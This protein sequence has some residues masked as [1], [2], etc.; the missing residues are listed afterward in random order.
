MNTNAYAGPDP[1]TPVTASSKPSSA[2]RTQT[3]TLRIKSRTRATSASVAREPAHA[4]DAASPTAHGVLGITR[5]T[6][7]TSV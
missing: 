1:L 6:R 2:T 7:G 5:T 4:P 3:P